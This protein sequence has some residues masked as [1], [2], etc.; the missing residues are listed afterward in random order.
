MISSI[1]TKEVYIGYTVQSLSMA[2][3]SYKNLYERHSKETLGR[4]NRCFNIIKYDDC[5]I[6]LLEYFPCQSKVELI[7]RKSEIKKKLK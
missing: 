4:N 2:L 7:K 3:S 5:K 1:H 6:T